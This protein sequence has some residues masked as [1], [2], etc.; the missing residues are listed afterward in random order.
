MKINLFLIALVFISAIF[1]FPLSVQS[2]TKEVKYALKF[3]ISPPLRDM[4]PAKAH[5]W[6]K[7]RRENDMEVPNKFRPVPP[8]YNPDGAL[9]KVYYNGN[10]A[11]SVLPIV[12]FEG[13]TN[14]ANTGRVTPPDPAGD[15]GPNHYV[16]VVNSALQIFTKTGTSLYGP[17]ATSTLWSGFS[18]NWDGHNDGDA[19]VLYDENADRWIISQFAVDCPGTPKTEYEMVAVSTTGDPLGTYYRYAFQFDYMPDYPKLGVWQDG[20]YMAINRFNTN[21]GSPF[22]GVGAVVMERSKMLIGDASAAMVYFKTE[23]LGGSGSAAGSSC[24]AMMPSDCDG[25]FPAAG[26]P[27][28]FTYIDGSSELRIWALHA[29]WTN[30]ANTTFT[31]VTAL[32]VAAYTEMGSGSVPEQGTLSLDA[33]GDRLMF[34]NQYRNFGSYETFVTC[35]SVNS[36]GGVAGIRW[37]EYRKVGST[38][39]LYQQSTFAP[40]DGKSRWMASIAMNASGDIGMAYSVSSST[41]YPSIYFTGR[42]AADPLNQ[43]TI[44]EGLIHTGTVSMTTYSRWGDYTATNVDPVDNTTFWTQQEFVGTY[45]GWCPWATKIASFRFANVPIVAT[46]AA[47]AI[48]TTTAT[49]NATVNPNGYATTYHFEYGATTSYGTSTSTVSAGSG[50]AALSVNANLT[51]LVP[52]TT[53]HFRIVAVNS[54]GTSNGNDLTFT[55]GVAVVTTTA[56]SGIT[57]TSATSGGVVT[58]DGG[59]TVTARGV[60]W[61]TTASPTILGSHTT[62]GSGLGTF[63]SSITGLSSSTTYHVRAYATTANGTSYGDDLQ[64][65][66]LCGIYTLPFTESFSGTTIPTCWTQIDHSG[67]GQVWLFGTISGETPIPALTGNYA[68]LNS[69]AYGSG[70]SQNAD[71]ISPT[72]NLTNFSTVNLAFNHYFKS[73]SGSS[74]TLAYSI[75]NGTTWT[76]ITT[77]TTTTASNPTAFSQAVNAVAGQSLVKFKWNYTGTFGWYWAIDD[78]NITG[79]AAG[80]PVVSTTAATSVTATTATSGGNVTSA[81]T[82]S[83]T[84]R[85]VCWSTAVNPTITDSH[86]TDGAGAGVFTSSIT[87]LTANTLYHYRAYASNT[88]GTSYGSDLTFTTLCGS[89][90]ITSFPWTEGFENAGSIPGCWTQEQVNSSGLNW[91]FITG[92]GSSN[93]ATAHT[94]TYN[95]CL[96]DASSATNKTKLV[97]P[98][99]DISA[100][101]T[102]KLKFWHTQAFWSPDQDTLIVF[103]KTSL[104]GTWT[105]LAKYSASITTWTQDSITLPNPSSTYYVAFEGNAVYGYGVCVD[106]VSVTSSC[107]TTYPVSISIVASSNPVCAGTSVT[108]TATPTN[109]GSTPTYQWKVNN[110]NVGANAST[111]T[112]APAAS[113][114]VTCVLTSNLTCS[115]GNPATSNSVTMTVNPLLPASVAIAAS[116]NPVCAGTSVTFTATPTNGGSTPTYQWKVNSTS[117]GTNSTTYSYAP[118][119]GDLVTCVLTSNATCASGSPATSNT[120]TMT[121][122]PILPVSVSIVASSNPVCAGT[123]VTFTPTATN[124][125][126]PTYQWYKNTVAVSTAASYSYTP[127]NG[128]QVYVVMTSSLTC[129]SGSPATSNV[130]TMA[131]NPL[132]PV[133]VSIAASSNPVCSGT[134]VTFTPT[135]TNGGTPA[136]QWYKNTVA[137]STAATYSFTPSNSDQVYVTMT[138]SL[139]C[140]SGSPATSNTVVMTVNPLLPASNTVV[141]SSNPVCAGTSVAFTSTPTNGG[142]SPSYQ[143]KVNASNVGSNSSTFSYVPLNGD[144]V[145]CV[146]TSN[147]AC[148]TGSPATSIAINMTVNPALPVSVAVAPSANPVI[149]GTSVT[150]TATPTN[151]GPSP[152]YQWSVNALNVGTNSASYTY[153][154]ANG[155]VVACS[156][157]SNATCAAGSPAS[158]SVTMSV[159]PLQ[160]LVTPANQ[161]VPS[162][163]GSANY[164]VTS[165]TA[166]SVASDQSWCT[167]TLSGSGNGSIV[168]NYASNGTGLSRVAHI[169]VSATGLTPVVVT[170]TQG[171]GLT[172]TLNLV[173][174]LECLFNGSAMNQAMDFVSGSIVPRYGAGIADQLSIELHNST[175]PYATTNTFTG[176][177][178]NT[179]GTLSVTSIPASL[180]GSYY[181][182]VKH[183]NSMETWSKLPVSF[184]GSGSV[185]YNFSTAASQAYGNNLKLMGST[186][187][188]F[189]GDI[190]VDGI[191]DGS[192]LALVDNAS[193]GLLHGYIPQDANGDGVTDGSDM[194]IVDNNSTSVIQVKKP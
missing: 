169:T 95:A 140:K 151:G 90:S 165:N 126:S 9:Q 64:F 22:V 15:V 26:T 127:V 137:V 78:I 28:Y 98:P 117:V 75:D 82:S 166:W 10:K 16:Q 30:T 38:F 91:T 85:G 65:T 160:L 136:Y 134:A 55:P 124:G 175:A 44:P 14:A 19:I 46:I 168:A 42:K 3:D 32:P 191:V 106:D 154:P 162:T 178:L 194:A 89:S 148:V 107:S 66:T 113:D 17:V 182:V 79:T 49:L 145:V 149:V 111:Y 101:S 20:Y 184:S 172:K 138:S 174:Y 29:D 99:L 72:L 123:A 131:V 39:S 27:N 11:A 88:A 104:A 76:T 176:L 83:V 188:I 156:L 86:T 146:M 21:A 87:G 7:W 115:S 150:F 94:G 164:T 81:G 173:C 31:Y 93:P 12:N 141:P 36:G 63:T 139:T 47:S 96:K 120:V 180:S 71:L 73:Y 5:F 163:A 2:Q 6:E 135:P 144:A 54:E 155:D 56:A 167:V 92:N 152:V 103:Y 159:T 18:G 187:V 102:P 179:N 183:R 158:N 60:C 171:N 8:G 177:N 23:T 41:M 116:A 170:L 51:G 61:S 59:A 80:P 122:N 40:G 4:K 1:L 185:T 190:N 69:D 34:R 133:S 143:W 52:G 100:L 13:A 192:D 125:G 189:G 109:G 35:H 57:L 97:T 119:N 24:W 68:Y 114:I 193:T 77:F 153:I 108:F 84:A 128:D 48:T 58:T 74:G 105:Q 132:L 25:T 45:G 62:D 118:V 33:L 129:K 186:W 50:T 67:N 37:Y 161:D 70:S 110:V 112:Y 53:Y 157:T 43:M 121:V 181:I 147:A 142:S 130:I